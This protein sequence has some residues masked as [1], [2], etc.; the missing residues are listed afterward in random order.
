MINILPEDEKI[1]GLGK[2]KKVWDLFSGAGLFSRGISNVGL[3]PKVAIEFEPWHAKTYAA[4]FENTPVLMK[5]IRKIDFEFLSK[6]IGR[7]NFIIG[8]IPCEGFSRARG[9]KGSSE[10]QNDL[11]KYFLKAV[12]ISEP[13]GVAIEEVPEF[14]T[15]YKEGRKFVKGLMDL[16]YSVSCGVVSSMVYGSAQDRRRFILVARKDGF[17]FLPIPA[18]GTR[19]RTVGE[20]FSRIDYKKDP[21]ATLHFTTPKLVRKIKGLKQGEVFGWNNQRRL[22]SKRPSPTILA[23]TGALHAHPTSNRQL[24]VREV[25]ELFDVPDNWK[26]VGSPRTMVSCLGDSVPI[27]LGT[28]IGY[29]L[30]G[31]VLRKSGEGIMFIDMEKTINGLSGDSNFESGSELKS[32]YEPVIEKINWDSPDL[33]CEKFLPIPKQEKQESFVE[34]DN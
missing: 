8:G 32:T 6:S 18:Q 34:K 27:K 3:I 24:T 20:A 16:G 10:E 33:D 26:F 2:G 23:G 11:Y 17:S 15:V 13:E 31:K 25:A 22:D 9:N 5:N 7:P 19:M 29:A 1:A 21:Y 12:E 28:A 14:L 4:N 30:M